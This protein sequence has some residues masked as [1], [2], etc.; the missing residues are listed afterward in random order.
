MK[1]KDI[2]HAVR[3]RIQSLAKP[4]S[5]RRWY[6][7]SN[8]DGDIAEIRIYDEI[9]WWGITAEDFAKELDEITAAEILVMINS[10]GGNVFDG[11]TIYNALRSH[12]AKVTTR[13]DGVAASIASVVVQ[14][15]DHRIMLSASQM[16]IHKAWGLVI[17]DSSDMRAYAE[18]LEKQDENL[19]G[20]YAARGTEDKAHYSE[21]MA[22]ETWLSDE[23]TVAIGLADEVLDPSKDESP[24]ATARLAKRTLHDEVTEAMDVVSKTITSAE[25]VAALRAEKGKDLSQVN[26]ISLDELESRMEQLR[27]LLDTSEVD[28]PEPTGTTDAESDDDYESAF[29]RSSEL[30]LSIDI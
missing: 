17:G 11:I 30:L 25:R 14:A 22:A 8:K 20:I 9:S 28:A 16:M 5:N 7:V 19:A 4:L 18:V 21:L 3:E 13:V 27:A 26:R 6:D 29:A 2:Q 10:P 15:G 1:T 24:A 12:P 23:E